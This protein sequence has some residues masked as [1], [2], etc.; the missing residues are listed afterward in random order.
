[1]VYIITYDINSAV[2]NYNDL[3]S[4]IKQLTGDF[5]HPLE[6]TWLVYTN[7]INLTPQVIYNRLRSFINEKDYLF[8]TRMTI[9]YYGWLSKNVWEWLK[10]REI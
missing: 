1:M 8:I 9:P 7:D 5:Q 3:Y 2:K 10:N 4:G 6:S